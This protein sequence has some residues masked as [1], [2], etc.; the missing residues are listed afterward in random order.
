MWLLS[1]LFVELFDMVSLY[2]CLKGN[3]LN[4]TEVR[5]LDCRNLDN[6]SDNNEMNRELEF[7]GFSKSFFSWM[8]M[9]LVITHTNHWHPFLRIFFDQNLKVWIWAKLLLSKTFKANKKVLFN[10]S[11]TSKANIK[12]NDTPHIKPWLTSY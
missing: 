12:I 10:W 6:Q 2:L 8:Q 3:F 5:C 11:K 9:V 1:E 7:H 4:I